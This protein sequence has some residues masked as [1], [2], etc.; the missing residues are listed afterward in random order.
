MFYKPVLSAL[1]IGL[2]FVAYVPYVRDIIKG[3]TKPHVFSWITWGSTTIIAFFAQVQAHGGIGAWPIG[4]SG[5]ITLLVAALAYARRADVGITKL[6]WVFFVAAMSSLP[7]WYLTSNPVWAVVVLTCVD[8]L[9]FG[10][11]IRKIRDQPHSESGA[12]Y[13]GFALRNALVVM[14]LEEYSWA[15]V[16][17]PAGVG[18][19]CF[20][21][22]V[23]I[24]VRRQ[25]FANTAASAT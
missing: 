10:P 19:V 13:G 21:V 4:V 9:G 25:Q 7:I 24:M 15:T 23:F 3:S 6:D 17:F 8:I 11:T 14:A 18:T 12:F 16:L 2:T 1:A 20:L 22:T 5:S